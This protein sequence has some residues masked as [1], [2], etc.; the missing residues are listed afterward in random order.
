MIS[1]VLNQRDISKKL[2]TSQV[3]FKS[4]NEETLFYRIDLSVMQK[5]RWILLLKLW[6]SAEPCFYF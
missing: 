5:G 3:E 1:R 4:L 2:K 6:K